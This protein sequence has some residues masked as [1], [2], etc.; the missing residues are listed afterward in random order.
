MKVYGVERHWEQNRVNKHLW[1]FGVPWSPNFVL[2]LPPRG[3]FWTQSKWPWNMIHSMPR[4]NPCRLYIHLAFHIL[5]GSLNVVWSKLG[6]APP[7]PPMRVIEVQ[8]SR[9]L[10]INSCNRIITTIIHQPIKKKAWMI[11]C[12]TT[13]HPS[14][15]TTSHE[16]CD[17]PLVTSTPNRVTRN[18]QE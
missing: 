5:R 4:R 17:N 15:I 12:F 1:A 10:S 14:K 13:F 9:A 3:G 7:F 16:Q 11:C 2:G 8:R 18:V 6:P